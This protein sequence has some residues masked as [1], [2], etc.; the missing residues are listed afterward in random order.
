[1]TQGCTTV[2]DYT[3]PVT[4]VI[5]LLGPFEVRV[6]G[7]PL[8]RVRSRKGWWLLALLALR[9]GR[10]V[11]RGWLAGTLWPDDGEAPGLRSLRQSLHDLRL[12]LGPEA[13]RL[14]SDSS[15]TLHLD[16]TGTSVDVLDFDAAVRR[17]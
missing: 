6:N 12:A 13:H 3:T 2:S 16:V 7:A 8:P 10:E 4:L 15:R 5:R 14:A 11:E 1:M 17:G 9:A